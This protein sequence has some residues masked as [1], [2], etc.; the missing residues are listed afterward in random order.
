MTSTLK[1]CLTKM[2]EKG[3]F[4]GMDIFDAVKIGNS[5]E[6]FDNLDSLA[7]LVARL[8]SLQKMMGT[9]ES[10]TGGLVSCL[11][12]SIPGSSQWF[13]G[14]IVAYSNE[15]KESILK[16]DPCLLQ[17]YGAVSEESA[18]AMAKG[19]RVAL[20]VYCALAVTG[21]AGPEGGSAEKPVGTVCFA[22]D[23]NGKVTSCTKIF[24][25]PRNSVRIESAWAALFGLLKRL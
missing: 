13:K 19:A 23:V 3:N 7:K 8:I 5:P 15:I 17:K 18:Q 20:D 4:I 24:P 11:L 12:T 22:W 21:I 25:G 6:N 14:G 10:C 2:N 16:V 1:A 9:A